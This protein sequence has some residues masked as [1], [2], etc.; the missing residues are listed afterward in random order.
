MNEMQL[1]QRL[2]DAEGR[3]TV[4]TESFHR[5]RLRALFGIKYDDVEFDGIVLDLRRARE[6]ATAARQAW[7]RW[8]QMG[9]S[10]PPV[11]LHSLAAVA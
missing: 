6:E 7:Q 2:A 3:L 10:R 9:L 1:A 4:M 5:A 8:R 11:G